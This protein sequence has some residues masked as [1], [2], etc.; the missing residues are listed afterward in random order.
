MKSHSPGIQQ[1]PG[2]QPRLRITLAFTLQ[3]Q[4]RMDSNIRT[5]IECYEL[6]LLV[7]AC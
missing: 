2:V 7:D 6:E 3:D 4:F 5:V 1:R